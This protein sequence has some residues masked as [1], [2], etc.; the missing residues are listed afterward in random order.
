MITVG[1]MFSVKR[2]EFMHPRKRGRFQRLCAAFA[3]FSV[4]LVSEA[5]GQAP[6][7]ADLET[8]LITRLAFMNA[9]PAS[10]MFW[11]VALAM[12]DLSNVRITVHNID[13]NDLHPIAQK[14]IEFLANG[15]ELP[16]QF[17]LAGGSGSKQRLIVCVSFEVNGV[18]T[19]VMRFYSMDSSEWPPAPNARRFRASVSEENGNPRMCSD[20]KASAAR[21]L[22]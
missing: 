15:D 11:L 10:G 9:S 8:Q 7:K 3:A 18:K 12:G 6:P 22:K 19:D 20:V 5:V 14:Q 17:S 21:F 16:G 1:L 2:L 13:G 4:V